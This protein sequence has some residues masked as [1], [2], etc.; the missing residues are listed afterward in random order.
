MSTSSL[1]LAADAEGAP[2]GVD[3]SPDGG[4]ST[5]WVPA[6]TTATSP[7]PHLPAD[8]S[9]VALLL[10][11]VGAVGALLLGFECLPDP[12]SRGTKALASGDND[13]LPSAAR[14]LTAEGPAAAPLLED[15]WGVVA[16]L[17]LLLLLLA[18]AAVGALAGS[19]AG[20]VALALLPLHAPAAAPPPDVAATGVVAP[21]PAT[22]LLAAAAAAA[23]GAGAGTGA[24]EVALAP[25]LKGPSPAVAAT[26]V[27]APLPAALLAIEPAA[28]R[29]PRL[30]AP[31]AS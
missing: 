20:D 21:L 6:W 25:A 8:P 5:P 18:A 14:G 22:L 2:V 1:L 3:L 9:A 19:G 26:G 12:D 29:L 7:E 11:L 13:R 31:A 16:A 28:E 23:D 27:V 10:R 4:T 24:G 30:P 17:L 15:A